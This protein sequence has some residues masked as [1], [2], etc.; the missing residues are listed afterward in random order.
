[1]NAIWSKVFSEL[2]RR[3]AAHGLIDVGYRDAG[4]F[5]IAVKLT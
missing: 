1:M 5:L 4:S 2:G 3:L